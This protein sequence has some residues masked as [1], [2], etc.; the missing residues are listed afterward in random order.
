MRRDD[1]ELYLCSLLQ[2]PVRVNKLAPLGASAADLRTKGYGYGT[3]IRVDYETADGEPRHAV[4]H[5]I[6][7]GGFGHEHL[8]DRAQILL[9]QNH[10]FNSLPRHVRALDVAGL[11]ADGEITSVG[12]VEE[13]F[14]VT[15]YVEGDTYARD[16]QRIQTEGAT[17][18]CQPARADALTDYLAAIH[19]DPVDAPGLYARRIRELVGHNECLMG[20]VDSY[21]AESSVQ[22]NDLREIEHLAVDWRWRLKNRS[23]RLRQVHGDFHPWNILFQSDVEFQLLDRSRGEYGEPADDVTCLTINY[24]FFSLQ[25][26]GRLDNVFADLFCRVWERYLQKTGDKEMLDVAA[27][28]FAFRSLVLA[29]P[30]WYPHLEEGVRSKL[31]HFAKSVLGAP[32][33]EPHEVNRYCCV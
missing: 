8:A 15:E 5:T 33:F 19:A 31:I 24:L 9:W 11:G 7:A 12:K 18:P 25:Q 30:V 2:E 28:F 13:F 4:I 6:S 23:H 16:L 1:I 22:Q 17:C 3:P 27:P 10:A 29:S 14:L 20:I 21:P 32:S 26:Y